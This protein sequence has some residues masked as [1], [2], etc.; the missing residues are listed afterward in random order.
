MIYAYCRVSTQEQ[1]DHGHGL[2]AQR[3]TISQHYADEVLEWVEDVAS[4]STLDR[5][6]LDDLLGRI[7]QGD[8]LV[9]A[10]LDRI[11]RSV[12]DWCNLVERSTEEGRSLVAL[13][14]NLDT[15]TS[16]GRFMAHI[17]VAFAQM[18]RE[19]ISERTIAGLAAAREKGVQLGRPSSVSEETRRSIIEMDGAQY[20]QQEIANSL[21]LAGI[22]AAM[23]GRWFYQGVGRVLR[24]ERGAK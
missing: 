5:P 7:E 18:E 2:S 23:G 10:K 19:L 20:T 1:G 8:S 13:D 17:M 22:P 14:F 11:S 3:A 12:I 9:V 15:G 16:A 4:G 6:G 24:A 21:N